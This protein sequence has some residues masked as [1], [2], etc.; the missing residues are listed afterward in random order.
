MLKRFIVAL[1]VA[2]GVTAGGLVAASAA[3]AATIRADLQASC[4]LAPVAPNS[5]EV[6]STWVPSYNGAGQ[7]VY[8]V[9]STHHYGWWGNSFDP[10]TW[11]TNVYAYWANGT[12]I[13]LVLTFDVGDHT[14]PIVETGNSGSIIRLGGYNEYPWQNQGHPHY[15]ACV[16]GDASP[17]HTWFSDERGGNGYAG[18]GWYGT[19]PHSQVS[20]GAVCQHG[21]GYSHGAWT[22]L[23][24][25]ADGGSY[26]LY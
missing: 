26:Y 2:L 22:N 21:Y 6:C 7:F 4:G 24:N 9:D 23:Q 20:G 17:Q 13:G 16:P 3:G 8:K 5:I 19:W 10:G 14:F 1:L 11:H 15:R 25:W 12:Y 18:N